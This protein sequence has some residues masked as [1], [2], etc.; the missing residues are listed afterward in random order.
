M[1][2]SGGAIALTAAP[3][4]TAAS[5][6]L[7]P[8]RY[9]GPTRTTPFPEVRTPASTTVVPPTS[10]SWNRPAPNTLPA[11]AKAGGNY[12]SSQLIKMEAIAN[13]YDEGIAHAP[14]GI[15]SEGSGQNLFLVRDGVLITPPLEGTLLLIKN[16]DQP[17]VIGEVGTIL[18]KFGVNIANFALGR[19][20]GG[21]VGV[22]NID[23]PPA[24]NGAIER[25]LEAIRAI[26]AVTSACLV[27]FY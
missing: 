21:A 26:P 4:G 2:Q 15:I 7:L 8:Q 5:P 10:V 17:G 12:L 22:V 25:A 27:K 23:V 13:G 20:K 19:G 3:S 14:N 18:G 11:M 9:L 6:V 16:E 24:E 1:M